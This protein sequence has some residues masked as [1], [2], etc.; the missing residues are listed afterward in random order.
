MDK[1]KNII[2]QL[3]VERYISEYINNKTREK[4]RGITRTK[5]FYL[6]DEPPEY[7]DNG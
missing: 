3:S 4:L 7:T 6:E 5:R 2:R 1:L